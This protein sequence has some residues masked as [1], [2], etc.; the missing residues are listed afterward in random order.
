[1][2]NGTTICTQSF[3]FVQCRSVSFVPRQQAHY[4]TVKFVP[5]IAPGG[6]SV[7][8]AAGGGSIVSSVGG[9]AQVAEP[10]AWKKQDFGDQ[11]GSKT[12]NKNTNGVAPSPL[13]QWGGPPSGSLMNP[14]GSNS[15][16]ASAALKPSGGR[17]K[18]RPPAV[19]RAE[20]FA[21]WMQAHN[22]QAQSKVFNA[23]HIDR[24]FM[25]S[26]DDSSHMI[27]GDPS[28]HTEGRTE[29]E[30]R[31]NGA[32]G[33]L[34][35]DQEDGHFVEGRRGENLLWHLRGVETVEASAFAC[36]D[37]CAV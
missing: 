13:S 31:E 28:H 11:A 23:E 18:A 6:G 29:Q 15:L 10:T 12:L 4:L 7:I 33:E 22:I 3:K 14:N 34:R 37:V 25:S 36:K 16:L 35:E 27:D 5:E 1:M 8:S 32:D 24:A 17:R 30:Q 19:S 2:Y 21:S 26:N 9:Q 20:M